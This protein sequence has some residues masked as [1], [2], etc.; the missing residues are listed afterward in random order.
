MCG[1]NGVISRDGADYKGAVG[2][3]QACSVHRGPDGAG[4]YSAPHVDMAMRRLS[5]IDLNSGWQPLYNEDRS[6]A[7]VA[8]GEVYNYVELREE[9]RARGHQFRTG[10]DCEVIVHLYEEHG[11]EF[12]HKL[13]GM[14]AFALWDTKRRRLVLVRDRMGEKP[15][16][17]VQGPS[18]LAFS[19]ELRALIASGLVP[20]EIDHNAIHQ[21]FYYQYIPE[22][23]TSVRNIVK[24]PPGHL[25]TVDVD[26]WSINIERYWRIEDAPEVHGDPR[27]AIVAGLEE[28]GRLIV[29]A[30][31]PIGVALSGGVDS[32]II[33]ALVARQSKQEVHA[34][35]VGYAGRPESDERSAASLLARDLKIPFHEVEVSTD[36]VVAR[37]PETVFARDEPIA[38]ISGHGYWAVN[39]AAREAGVP[40]M[41]QGHG[42]DE[43]FWGYEWVHRAATLSEQKASDP[44]RLAP[45]RP[46]RSYLRRPPLR[47]GRDLYN[48]GR[49]TFAALSHAARQRLAAPTIHPDRLVF[50]DLTPDFQIAERD[51][52]GL[53]TKEFAAAVATD[54]AADVWATFTH[55]RPWPDV[56]VLLTALI[57]RGYLLV[58]G[59]AQGDRL[60]MA[61]S[62]ELR[63]P[64]IDYKF[65][66]MVV[67]LR[68]ANPDH[69]LPPKYWF[70]QAARDMLSPEILARPK[71]GFTPP[72]F[73]WHTALFERYGEMIADGYLVNSHVLT[74]P[75]AH[76]LARGVYTPGAIAPMCFKALVF[77]MWLSELTSQ[78]QLTTATRAAA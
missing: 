42:G 56:G 30:D 21:Y 15:L 59:I 47:P 6:L 37:F 57:S 72:V 35:T 76:E 20:L 31:V 75:A 74:R 2:R 58:N 3:M 38:D 27:E 55:E 4:E 64:L 14:Y 12:V 28:I 63:L 24:L 5:I 17:Y 61:S 66:E 39:R 69:H 1:I 9:L 29:R 50:N 78:L 53:Y 13:R 54:P 40:V 46:L 16:C 52:A 25:M 60:S 71:R 32:S 77:E 10:S 34:F 73:Q 70:M 65:V 26:S 43:L 48:W 11:L 44:A 23:Y 67:G 41:I 33:A 62:V 22:P 45:A 36:E 19:S 51:L 49:G 8:N 18:F 68:K 7:L